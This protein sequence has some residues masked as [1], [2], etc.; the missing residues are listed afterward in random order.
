MKEGQLDDTDRRILRV[1]AHDCRISNQKLAEQVSLSATPCWNRVKALEFVGG[2]SELLHDMM[3]LFLQ[4]NT[5]LLLR[6]QEAIGAGNADGICEAAHAYKGAV[7]HFAAVGVREIAQTLERAGR[8]NQ[9]DDVDAL[10]EL[11]L[12]EAA[13]LQSELQQ[14]YDL[15]EAQAGKG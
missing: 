6:V 13:H 3:G 12:T 10:W 4:R 14:A 2:D 11:L 9:L 7:N 15:E 8:N 5:Q 1:L